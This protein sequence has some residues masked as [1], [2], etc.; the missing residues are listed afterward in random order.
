MNKQIQGKTKSNNN[1]LMVGGRGFEPLTSSL[2]VTRSN[3]LS[4][5][6]IYINFQPDDPRLILPG[7]VKGTRTLD[8]LG[9]NEALYQLSYDP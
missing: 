7:G 2:S 6:P 3:Q 5:S 8:L 4:Y 9:A 1:T